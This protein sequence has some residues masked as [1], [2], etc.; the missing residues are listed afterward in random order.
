MPIFVGFSRGL[1]PWDDGKVAAK[2][3]AGLQ[4]V[5]TS[6]FAANKLALG[7]ALHFAFADQATLAIEAR[8][9]AL[10]A[11]RLPRI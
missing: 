2:A 11:E 7:L 5:A 9:A 10:G 1:T 6:T 8:M 4:S 3:A